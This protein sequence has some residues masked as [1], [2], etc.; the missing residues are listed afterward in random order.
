MPVE[1][2]MKL[3]YDESWKVLEAAVQLLREQGEWVPVEEVVNLLRDEDAERSVAG[4]AR[5]G[6]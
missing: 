2:V 3:L 5:G 4:G 1:E 6:R